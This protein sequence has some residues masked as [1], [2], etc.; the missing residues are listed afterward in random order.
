MTMAAIHPVAQYAP[1]GYYPLYYYPPGTY[2]PPTFEGPE[3]DL[4][5]PNGQPMMPYI[6]P[7]AYPAFPESILSSNVPTTRRT[8][9]A[10]RPTCSSTSP[11][12]TTVATANHQS[13]RHCEEGGRASTCRQEKGYR[14]KWHSKGTFEVGP[15]RRTQGEEDECCQ[16]PTL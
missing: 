15:E 1:E 13:H 4:P 3:C 8:T 5:H 10:W 11:S 14:N 9:P 16:A 2:L 12:C 6:H 7:V